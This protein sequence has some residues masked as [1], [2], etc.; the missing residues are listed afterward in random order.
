MKERSVIITK[1]REDAI[2]PVYDYPDRAM[3]GFFTP[4][5]VN[6]EPF[7]S[8]LVN[9][10]LVMKFD[11]S[12]ELMVK[13]RGVRFGSTKFLPASGSIGSD[14]KDEIKIHLVSLAPFPIYIPKGER[15]ATGV[16]APVVR[17][18]LVS[19]QDD[20]DE[21]YPFSASE[22]GLRVGLPLDRV[23]K[24]VDKITMAFRGSGFGFTKEFI[25]CGE[26]EGEP[27]LCIT[28]HGYHDTD[29]NYTQRRTAVT[30]YVGAKTTKVVYD[31]GSLSDDFM[32]NYFVPRINDI[33]IR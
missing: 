17:M 23:K 10:G 29:K 30:I 32:R 20:T 33:P 7:G 8:V 11:K 19:D 2:F 5:E 12:F 16:F 28:V 22:M 25:S 15:I 24:Y 3:F 13:P 21:S 14:C 26:Y 1:L 27:V 18:K 31:R 4:E 9:T 6:I